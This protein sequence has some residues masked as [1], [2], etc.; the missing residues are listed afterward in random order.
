MIFAYSCVSWTEF[1]GKDWLVLYM[2]RR[3]ARESFGHGSH[4]WPFE[5]VVKASTT[6]FGFLDLFAKLQQAEG[7]GQHWCLT[8][9]GHVPGEDLS[10]SG[11][12]FAHIPWNWGWLELWCT[13]SFPIPCI[14]EHSV[15]GWVVQVHLSLLME[16]SNWPAPWFYGI[17]TT[18]F[19]TRSSQRD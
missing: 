8:Q 4:L 10:T 17:S 11:R 6:N 7:V 2:S 9:K 14:H 13:M 15:N 3:G 16:Y 18:L 1:Y 19:A 12:W 5:N